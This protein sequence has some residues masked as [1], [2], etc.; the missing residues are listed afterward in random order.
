MADEKD[1]RRR[2]RRTR[3]RPG[4]RS[5]DSGKSGNAGRGE[6][7]GAGGRR[8]RP[9]GRGRGQ[10]RSRSARGGA[11]AH[12]RRAQPPANWWARRWIEVLEGFEVGRRLGRGRTYAR[13]GQVTD[14][15]I[16]KGF[17]TAKV[18]GSRDAP[19]LV[20]MRFSMLS[21]TD[22]KKVIKALAGEPQD[23]AQLLGGEIP[24]DIE[25][26][27]RELELSLLPSASGD[28]KT[29]CSCPDKAN[30]CKHVAAVYYLLGEAFDRDPFL[31]FRLRGIERAELIDAIRELGGTSLTSAA[32]SARDEVEVDA[33]VR[34]G[35]RELAAEDEASASQADASLEAA[36]D[37]K[38]RRADPDVAPEPVP[39]EAPP[40]PLPDE[41]HAFWAGVGTTADDVRE[42]RI[43]TIAAALPK[44]LGGL[45]FW[46]GELDCTP[47]IERIYR[48]A[49]VA[50]LDVFLGAPDGP[51]A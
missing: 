32:E 28:L 3:R 30:P 21:S 6:R 19:Y 39:R 11:R 51:E 15:E 20:R 36:D 9:G 25:E 17:I 8:S 2:R 49:S 46:Q 50:G 40:E 34:D 38:P 41:P 42:V 1:P 18:Q 26:V 44:R 35:E 12:G 13:Q 23:A 27:F 31:I 5:G 7:G 10:N 14:L 33:A 48:E 29:D 16:G 43:P 4:A 37:A 47:L 24:E 45:S 22:W